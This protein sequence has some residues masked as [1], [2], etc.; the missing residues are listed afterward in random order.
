MNL[1][2]YQLASLLSRPTEGLNVEIKTW[3]DPRQPEGVRILIRAV[4]AIRNRNGGFLVVGIND[5]SLKPDKYSFADPVEV[6]FHIDVI[7]AKISKYASQAFEVTVF[8]RDYGGQLHPIIA[9]PEGVK[10]PTLVSADLKGDDGKKLL[11]YGDLYFRTLN[12]NGTPSTAIASPR[13]YVDILDI[14]FENRETD[15]GRF[16]RRHLGS[17]DLYKYLDIKAGISGATVP[18]YREQAKA[19]MDEGLVATEGIGSHRLA[20][21]RRQAF[22]N[23]AEVDR[24][25]RHH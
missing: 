8:L 13:D 19:V 25:R 14:C 6:L 16:L 20:H 7:Q 17:D 3:F 12:S 15:I 23:F 22:R 18:T 11:A 9:V 5:K 21:R 1:D 2:E 4:F 24:L 10:V